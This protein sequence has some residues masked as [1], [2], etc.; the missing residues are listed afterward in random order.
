MKQRFPGDE[1][2]PGL[3]GYLLFLL[4]LRVHLLCLGLIHHLLH[5][6]DVIAHIL[7]Y[8]LHV[9]EVQSQALHLRLQDRHCGEGSCSALP[10]LGPG[11]LGTALCPASSFMGKL[12]TLGTLAGGNAWIRPPELAMCTRRL[13]LTGIPLLLL[14]RGWAS[15]SGGDDSFLFFQ[16]SVC[17]PDWA[18]TTDSPT[19]TTFPR[20]GL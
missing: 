5:D 4:Y 3:E 14:P 11:T 8:V 6:L 10:T 2:R 15:C 9:E 16:E 20:L 7:V 1:P 18:Q 12:E 19:S 13:E 17:I